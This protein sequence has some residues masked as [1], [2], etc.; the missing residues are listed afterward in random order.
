MQPITT[1]PELWPHQQ[2]VVTAVQEALQRG[3][4]R[5]LVVL[6][7]GGGKSR[8][9]G[10][11]SVIGETLIFTHTRELARQSESSFGPGV[12]VV[13]V[14]GNERPPARVVIVDE[15]HR[16]ASNEWRSLFERYS[17]AIIIGLT[18]TPCRADGRPL[19]MF[20][21]IIV[22]AHYSELIAGGFIVPCQVFY[23]AKTLVKGWAL[24][25]SE[26]T[27]K[28]GAG[29][30]GF[31]YATNAESAELI[32]TE[33]RKVGLRAEC[34]GSHVAA[35]ERARRVALFLDRQ[36]DFLTNVNVLTEGFNAPWASFVGL[37]CPSAHVATYLQRGGRG[38]RA[39]P[40]K[41]DY[42]LVDL[43]GAYFRHGSPTEDRLYS[44]TGQT[45]R[46]SQPMGAL[47]NCPAC[48]YC[49]ESG[50]ACPRCGHKRPVKKNPLLVNNAGLRA[51]VERRNTDEA[52]AELAGLRNGR[53]WYWVIQEYKKLFNR[54]PDLGWVTSDEKRLELNR[55]KASAIRQGK[56]VGCAY[57]MFNR[58]FGERES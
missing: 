12:R 2:R 40:G 47:T 18:A 58:M 15:V 11:L 10:A 36:L 22:G 28:Y 32:A 5:L 42:V 16:Y 48:G 21:E 31:W 6:P 39:Y 24:W 33:L 50:G 35:K 34:I 3:V 1:T 44:L 27:L 19:D 38:A 9:G 57:I 51:A 23:P 26:A 52:L 29:R 25:P 20:E 46:R 56:R 45:I 8:I 49:W 14:Q 41:T 54:E 30:S 13:T 4:K 43:C 53:S 17:D 55:L 37:A 7:T